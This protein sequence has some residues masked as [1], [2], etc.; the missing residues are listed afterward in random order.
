VDL[1][2][3]PIPQETFGAKFIYLDVR[4]EGGTA[5]NSW[6]LW[7]GPP[8]DFFDDPLDD[9]VNQRNLQ[10][11]NNPV[12]YS[13]GLATFA[14][15]RMPLN[16]YLSETTTLHISPVDILFGGRI[17]YASHFGL[18]PSSPPPAIN[19]TI[20]SASVVLDYD[21]LVGSASTDGITRLCDGGV[22][23]ADS[24][25]YPHYILQIPGENDGFAGDDLVAE[26]NPGGDSHTFSVWIT[27][28]RAFL[29]E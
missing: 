13:P 16:H 8:A 27:D 12:A 21:A 22:N 14:L 5:K 10:L 11:A 18:N 4:S 17:L 24:W 6:D 25:A 9:D 15:G 7:A 20:G 26:F 3:V 2:T 1:L 29:T 19:F 28:G 23:C